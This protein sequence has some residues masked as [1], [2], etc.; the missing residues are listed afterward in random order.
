MLAHGASSSVV[1]GLFNF[2]QDMRV[3][4]C[5]DFGVFAQEAAG[6]VEVACAHVAF[7]EPGRHVRV[8]AGGSG[9]GGFESI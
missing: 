9:C 1:T 5:A 3:E 7:H 4:E 8:G 2:A 6:T